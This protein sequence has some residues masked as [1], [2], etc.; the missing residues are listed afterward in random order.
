MK[1]TI[2]TLLSILFFS[3]PKAQ[4]TTFLSFGVTISHRDAEGNFAEVKRSIIQEM[5]I[6]VNL[7][8]NKIQFLSKGMLSRDTFKLKNEITVL[9]EIKTPDMGKDKKTKLFSGIDGRGT[10]CIVRLKPIRDARKML[11]GEL[12]VEYID[13]TETY[14]LRTPRHDPFDN[15]G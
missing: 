9:N 3:I 7:D 2:L 6:T 15:E 5:H 4:V 12:E 11:D 13:R 1:K 8:Q 10:K 14:K